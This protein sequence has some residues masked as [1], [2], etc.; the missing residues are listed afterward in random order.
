MKYIT[1]NYVEH[2][3][4]RGRNEGRHASLIGSSFTDGLA[5]QQFQGGNGMGMNN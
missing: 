1:G 2:M 4:M 5:P 3:H